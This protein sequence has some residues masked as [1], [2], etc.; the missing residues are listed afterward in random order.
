VFKSEQPK[1]WRTRTVGNVDSDLKPKPK[2]KL[3][4]GNVFEVS[5]PAA[6]ASS[7]FAHFV[8]PPPERAPLTPRWYIVTGKK[9]QTT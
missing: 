3:V 6:P 4:G 9:P 5:Q 1:P 8:K 2:L 7:F